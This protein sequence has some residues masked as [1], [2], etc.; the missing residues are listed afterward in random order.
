MDKKYILPITFVVVVLIQLWVPVS[1][2][3]KSEAVLREGREFHFKTAPIDPIDPF[4]GN[5]IILSF[6]ADEHLTSTDTTW[7]SNELAYVLLGVDSTGFAE[8]LSV[9]RKMPENNTD[10][11]KTSIYYAWQDSVDTK[12][13]LNFPFD[14][15][16]MEESKAYEAERAVRE[17]VS[18]STQVAYAIVCIKDG[19]ARLKDVMVDEVPIKEWVEQLMKELD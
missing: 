4:R 16:Y 2:I 19:E 3:W 18:D 5:Y 14:R 13:S 8:I 11:F 7:Q 17:S 6:D 12:L 15:Y 1:M 9:T 10:Y